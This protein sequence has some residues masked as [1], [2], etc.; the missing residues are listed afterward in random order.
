MY[1]AV[2]AVK[3]PSSSA[4]P[5]RARLPGSTALAIIGPPIRHTADSAAFPS[6]GGSAAPA[7]ALRLPVATG[8]RHPTRIMTSTAPPPR[9]PRSARSRGSCRS[10]SPSCRAW[11]SAPSARSA[12]A[13]SRSRSRSCSRSSSPARSPRATSAQIVLGRRHH[14][15][16]RPRRGRSGVAAPL[17][18]ARARD[19]GRVRPAHDVLPAPA[20]PARL[21]PRPLAVGA[22]AQP[23]DAGHQPASGAGSR[24]AS[25]C[26]SS[27]SSRSSSARSA[28]PL[29]LAARHD[30]PRCS[31]PLWYAGYRFE[32]RYGALARQSQD[33]A[34]DLATSVEESVHGIRVLKAFG[35][36]KHALQ[37]FARQAETPARDRA[38]QGPRGRAGSGSGSCCCPTSPSRC[39]WRGHRAR[40][41]RPAAGRRALRVLRD[42]DGAALADG[43]DRVPLL[44][45]A[46]RPHGDRPHLRGLRRGEHDRR[47]REPRDDRPPARRARVRGRALPV[48]GCPGIASATCSTASTSCCAPARRW[49]SSGSPGR[50]RR[51]SRRCPTR[52]YDVTAGPR[53]PR[54]RR[55]ARPDARRAAHATSAWPSRTRRCSRSPCA[56]TCCSGREDLE[57]GSAEAERVLREALDVAQ[58][59][60]VDDLPDGVDTV[61]GEEG[62]SLSGGQRQRLALARA[63]AARPAVLV[64]DDP[65]SALDV[66]TEALVEEALR[67]VLPPRPRSS[68]RTGPRPSRSPTASRCSRQGASPRSARTPSC[69]ARASTT[70]TSSRASRSRKPA[71]GRGR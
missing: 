11:C 53:H 28:L 42:G 32:K 70:G 54:R 13:S 57:P 49:R 39:A 23:H 37:K 10:R 17:V 40:R 51:R 5:A 63:V 20:A 7:H 33:Q 58:A 3:P 61:I 9:S 27:T 24:S 25:C 38:A 67:E 21:V 50:A 46:R 43:V 15:R 62:L 18:R 22:A 34:G 66:D 41:A 29:A 19:E 35:R 31:M 60:F 2:I 6:T 48:S 71:C 55:R 52:L 36:G 4:A 56:T 26:S 59:G 47:P 68:S 30:L 65:L 1:Q 16:A 64:L 44:V 69:C 12:R 8:I 45:P 14:P